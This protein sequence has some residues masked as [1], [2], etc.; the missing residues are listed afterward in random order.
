MILY[1]AAAAGP[2]ALLVVLGVIFL[3]GGSSSGNSGK[4]G[5]SAGAPKIDYAALAGL[6]K[7]PA[8]WPP[9]YAHESDRLAPLK[10]T[11]LPQEA[12]AEH[13]HAHLDI[14]V[15]GKKVQI[16]RFI[17]INDSDYIT[18][19]HT[20]DTRGV[21]H[22]E[23]P[24]KET[25]TLGQFVGNWGVRFSKRCIGGYCAK[26][27]KPLKVYVNGKLYRGDPNDIVIHAHDE[28]AVVYGKAPAKIPSSFKF[29]PGE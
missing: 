29:L 21:I 20:H 28:Y 13:I 16:P 24:K 14:F 1:G 19:L 8:P 12:L 2:I 18:E 23:G 25:F 9:E 7:G 6:E 15:D 11:A 10:L 26:A 5:T 17:G 22:V 4:G 27:G 3:G